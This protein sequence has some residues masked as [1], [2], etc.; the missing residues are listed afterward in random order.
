MLF[1]DIRQSATV[2]DYKIETAAVKQTYDIQSFVKM[3]E[4]A[5]QASS[6]TFNVLFTLYTAK[7]SWLF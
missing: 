2:S 5:A 4:L 1:Y 6:L 7:K 3:M